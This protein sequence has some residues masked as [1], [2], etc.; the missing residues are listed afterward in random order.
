[1]EDAHCKTVDEVV[2]HFNVNL[3]NGLSP[4]QVKRNQEKYGLNELPAEEGKS[5]WQLVLEQFDDLLVKILLLAA[6][7]S[8]VLALFEEHEDAF[9][10]FVEPFVILLILI[11]NAVVG[12]WQERN[13]ESAIEALKEYEPE[14]GK[15]VRGD[16][17]GVQRIRAKE[18]VPG[19]VVEISVGDKIPAD[20]RITKIFST[21][22]RIDQ[23]I[24]TGESV[25]VIK[26]TD[27]V[28]DPRA[29]NQDKK[30]IL[31]SGTNVAA[32]K[33]RGVVI[34]TGL[35][36]AIG[37]IRTEMSETEEIKTPLQ[38]KL[39]EFGE[40]LSKVISVICVA[41][42]AINIGHFN[43]PAHGGSWIKG[44]IYY[45]KIAV[46][47]AVAAIPEGLPAVITT[48][49]ALG[50]RRMAKK[51]AIVRSLPSVETLGCTSVICSD[52][53]GT[54]TTNQMSVSRMFVFEKI[55]GNDSNFH[56][57]EITGST[58]EPNGEVFLK[59]QKV[60]GADYETLHELG[61][62]CIMCN[63]SAI[64]FNEFKQAFEKV[65]EATETALI[66]LA[67]KI[68][69]YGVNKTGLDRRGTAIVVR[70]DIETKWKKEFTL[71]FSRDRK[72][73]SSY[74]VPLKATKL[75]TGPKLFVKGAPEGVLE[76]CTH[77]RVGSQKFPL[78]S[79]LKNRIL[80]LTRQ[81][82]T[83]RDTLRCLAL[84]TADHPMKPED[85]DLGDST[86]FYTYE[87][88]L[89][90]VGVVG[91]L[92]PPRKE[93]FDSIVRCRAAGIRVIVITGDNKA[94]AEAICRRIG[95]FGEDEDTTGKSYSGREFDDLSLSEQRAACAR[96][97]LFSRVEPAHKSKIVEF[98][99]SM[100][101]ISAMTGDGVNDA[102]ALK[103]AEI[104]IAMGSGT[105]V[106]KSAAEMVLADDN[107]SSIVA[108]VEEGRAIYNN[109]KQFIRYLIS[110]NIGEVVSIFLTA[111]LGLP[112][113]LIPVQLLWVNLVTDGLPAT[114]LGFNPPDLDIM[115]KPPRKADESLISG[116]LFFRYLAIG[117]YVGAATVG[118]AAWWFLYS[119]YGPQM[120]YYQLTHH[121]ACIGGGEEFKGIDCKVFSDPHPMTMALSVL[122]TIE[123]LNA[124]NSLSEN[125]SLVSMPPWSNLWLIA[126][127]A[128]SFTLHFVILH[129]EVLST[130]FQV[131]P[132]TAEEWITVLKFSLPV[133]LLDETLKFVARK[134]ADGENPIYTIHWIVLMWGVFFGLLVLGPI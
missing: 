88:D 97:R 75:G 117:G 87:K 55:D 80:D 83:G 84:A 57:F 34:G 134:I 4:D 130:V 47:L 39:D 1:M 74:C 124:M 118:S 50:T 110:S 99:Q 64:D 77:A 128:L 85:M 11:A 53:T 95:V 65:G 37:K 19:D 91:M 114:A 72:S 46:A 3:D 123:M 52:K 129:V 59:G 127:M 30:N 38:Q 133:V 115:Q 18:I 107:F 96:A 32:G 92:D 86:K 106:A 54:L 60:R 94:T 61:T 16:K 49:L 71:E 131:T 24:L 51:N 29:V 13:A 56:E 6:I 25:S 35:N 9:T 105:A 7:I 68:N 41:V 90:F 14:M 23:S 67:E 5:I 36:T 122:V 12:V 81:Y 17:S 125:Q 22:L 112:E 8:F 31:F 132:L 101:E 15:V 73:M 119:P 98:L 42:W 82:G 109:M 102:P 66:V 63:D 58:Y 89:T 76:R 121:L 108:A 93:V 69:P 28:P 120:N 44:A 104:G 113:A 33:A 116:W 21:T 70:Q 2:N 126:S 40:Q 78:T 20:I 27:P 103:K 10:A 62:I 43:D 45:F 100:N 79:T 48:C 26:H 111:A